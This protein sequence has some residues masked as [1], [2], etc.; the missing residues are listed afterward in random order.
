MI[1]KKNGNVLFD[2]IRIPS[3]EI[4]ACSFERIYFSRGSDVEIYNE[5][6]KLGATLAE[7]ILKSIDY[8]LENSVFFFH[9]KYR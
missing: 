1:I 3:A 4:K 5:R 6:K 8:D 9:T 2:T 7:P